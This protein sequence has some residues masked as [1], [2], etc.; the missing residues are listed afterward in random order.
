MATET[1]KVQAQSAANASLQPLNA[2]AGEW[3]LEIVLPSNPP[4]VVPG[5]ATFEWIEGGAFLLERWEAARL[6]I[7]GADDTTGAYTMLYYDSRAVSRLYQMSLKDGVWK[8][9]RDAPGFSQ[10]FEGKFSADGK[11]ITAFWEKSTDGVTWEL[12]FDMTYRKV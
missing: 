2:L 1:N 6:A 3:T 7:I 4:M 11:T 8:L 5:R 9:W 10:R 12:D